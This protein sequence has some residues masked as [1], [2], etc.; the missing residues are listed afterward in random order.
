[1]GLAG[2]AGVVAGGVTYYSAVAGDANV[3]QE[4][5]TAAALGAVVAY[6]ANSYGNL[7]S[8]AICVALGA[9]AGYFG[10]SMI[11]KYEGSK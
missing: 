3:M 8:P 10:Y 1:M 5:G 11:I 6:L 9:G 7:N 2:T 4:A